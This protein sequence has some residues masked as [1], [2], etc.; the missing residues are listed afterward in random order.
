MPQSLLAL[1]ALALAS[2][3]G[4]NQQ[5]LTQ[6]AYKNTIRDEVH[7]AASGTAQHV[8]ELIAAR[9]YDE[10]STPDKIYQAGAVPYGAALFSRLD[11]FGGGA[12]CDLMQPS[13]TP[14]CDDLDDLDGIRD[15]PAYA[16]L[17]DGRRLDFSVDVDVTYV[18]DPGSQTPSI[19]PTLHKRVDLTLRSDQLALSGES[20]EISRVVSYDPVAADAQM[21]S[22][23]G[24][25][26]GVESAT[27]STTGTGTIEE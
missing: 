26:I 17:S 19:S 10:V 13:L 22:F 3:I 2:L 16:R 14:G 4:F 9:S 20:I 21:E 25:P 18:D 24:G 15:A 23:C 6:K 5:R 1:L 8:M 27:C 11:Q 7:L 12:D